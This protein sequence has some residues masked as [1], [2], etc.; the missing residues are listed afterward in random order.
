M[1]QNLY[2]IAAA[3]PLRLA[4]VARPRGHD[5]LAE[6]VAALSRDGI[7]TLVSMLTAEEIVELG[8]ADEEKLCKESGVQFFN[9][10]IED[11]SLPDKN[12]IPTMLNVLAEEVK[13]GK[14]V[15]FH[16]RAGIGRSS[17]MAALVL[18][19]LGWKPEAA[20]AAIS[21]SRGCKVPDTPEQE[22]WVCNFSGK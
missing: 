3:R 7:N 10:P 20:F 4:I 6:E 17:M 15:G 16:C 19:Q 12:K 21:E 2:W 13:A 22:Q 14:G 9:F 18:A 5:W 1:P 11:R 8:L